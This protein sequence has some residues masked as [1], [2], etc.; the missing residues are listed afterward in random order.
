MHVLDRVSSRMMPA[1]HAV[2]CVTLVVALGPSL[3]FMPSVFAQVQVTTSQYD[4]ARTGA[5]THEAILTPRNV[6]VNQFGKLFT[7]RVDGDV[8]AQPLYLSHVAIPGKG[9]HNVVFIA[10]EYDSVYA[11]DADT[12]SQILWHTSFIDSTKGI[13]P[14]TP[15]EVS[16]PFIVPTIGITSTP[17]IDASSGTIYVLARTSQHGQFFQKLHALDVT[18]GA[19]RP[20]SPAT[21]KASAPHKTLGL[22]SNAVTFDPVR[23]NPRAALLLSKGKVYLSW[24]SSC[25]VGPYHGWMIAYDARTLQQL[26]VFNT[27]PDADQGGI[28]AGDAG[29]AADENGNIF[30][31][32][33]NG[34]F[35]VAS[36]AGRDYG[37]SILRLA[38]TSGGL[39][40][41][42]YF[43]PFD[44]D[45]L[46]N[47]DNDLGSGGPVLLPDQPGPHPHLLVVGGKGAMIYLI[48]RDRMGKF[49]AGDNSHAVQTISTTDA[50][51][52]AAAYWN[53]HL[54]YAVSHDVLRDYK[55]Q[56]GKLSLAAQGTVKFIDPG[57][58]PTISA[59]GAK[60]GVVWLIQSKGFEAEDRAAVLHAFDA[61]NVTRELYN[62]TQND[63]RDYAGRT[64]RFTIPTVANGRV[65]VGAKNEV[66]VYGLLP[67]AK[68]TR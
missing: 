43:T 39:N 44:Q 11:F 66:N 12:P 3:L 24:A 67:A 45:K 47:A 8:Y 9:T 38:L 55:L 46:N 37:D 64:L 21:I 17:V 13:A 54:Y 49:Y 19:E 16:C 65:Y 14:L 62:S 59:N 31:A 15:E 42:D 20:G 58:T 36:K 7:L 34:S 48:D 10:T 41:A 40:V 27:S 33:G 51:F 2:V 53:G 4:N 6:N 68:K 25:D 35:D 56:D 22:V 26:G 61:A 52:G 1:I 23:E 60:D 32:T 18:T 30:V 50:I 63:Q 29:P 5:D 28:W 57:A